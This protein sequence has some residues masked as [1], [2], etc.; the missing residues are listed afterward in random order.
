MRWRIF[1]TKSFPPTVITYIAT[2]EGW[3]YLTVL[4]DLYSRQVVGWSMKDHM[5]AS[6]VVD[7]LRMAYFRRKPDEGLI[8]H[9]DRGSLCQSD[10]V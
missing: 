7:A 6:L 9:S 1:L 2:D 5:Q 3:L 10:G 8:V 4:L